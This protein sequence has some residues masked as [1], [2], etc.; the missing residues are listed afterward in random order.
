MLIVDLQQLTLGDL[1]NPTE[2]VRIEGTVPGRVFTMG[3]PLWSTVE[4]VDRFWCLLLDGF[5]RLGVLGLQVER[6]SE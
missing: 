6:R 4:G 3:E 5:E 1:D 2:R